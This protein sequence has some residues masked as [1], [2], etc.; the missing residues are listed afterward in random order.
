ME[1]PKQPVIID[2][3]MVRLYCPTCKSFELHV[4]QPGIAYHC[5]NCRANGRDTTKS[6]LADRIN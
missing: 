6:L 5:L 2:I 4:L 1:N 3:M